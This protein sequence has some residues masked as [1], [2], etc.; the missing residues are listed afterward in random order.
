MTKWLPALLIALLSV[1]P[2][3][4]E[5]AAPTFAQGFTSNGQT[6]LNQGA[7]Y[8]GSIFIQPIA[9]PIAPSVTVNLTGVASHTYFIVGHDGAAPCGSGNEGHSKVS[10][11]TTISN[12]A[13][14]QNNSI[15]VP[16][17]YLFYDVLRDVTSA[18][19]AT[20]IQGGS[21]VV[22]TNQATAAYTPPATN[23]TG[24]FN[25]VTLANLTIS[26]M[27]T[28][29]LTSTTTH[30]GVVDA[31][32][33]SKST[34]IN[35]TTGLYNTPN[36]TL[37]AAARNAGNSA[38]ISALATDAANDIVLGDATNAVDIFTNNPLAVIEQTAPSGVASRDICWGDSTAHEVKCNNNNGGAKFIPFVASAQSTSVIPKFTGTNADASA[39]SITDNGTVVSTTEPISLPEA[40]AGTGSGGNDVCWPDSTNHGITCNF[41]NAGAGLLAQRSG[42]FVN[43]DCTK[44][45]VV[46][47]LITFVDAG[48]TCN[49]A[50]T[51]NSQWAGGGI[52]RGS[53]TAFIP[54]GGTSNNA[55]LI[56][57]TSAQSMVS[58]PIT[59]SKLYCSWAT[60]ST[61]T[62][63][64][65]KSHLGSITSL[66]VTCNAAPG[67]SCNDTSHSD[68]AVA[69]DLLD[70]QDISGGIGGIVY[71]GFLVNG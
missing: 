27:T 11:G 63:T 30:G 21:T 18:S 3:T 4:V 71:C 25:G 44:I 15:S 19:L 31:S 68:T 69:G 35:S 38:D 51:S 5:A 7:N 17:T 43:N 39:S 57:E 22:D 46:G 2:S 36:N 32:S 50:T 24:Q 42:A 26:T 41:N 62:F 53:G 20:C 23:T 52:N 60:N 40:G 70:I 49:V 37:I 65:R 16:T 8:I 64:V 48:S 14:P 59:I 6:V 9:D 29:T 1:L 45:S 33:Y 10:P 58:F 66:A 12:S 54:F 34:G 13:S 28:G 56:S 55:L 61:Q 47:S 67:T